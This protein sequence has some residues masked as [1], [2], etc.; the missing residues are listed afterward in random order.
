M[1]NFTF[2]LILLFSVTLMAQEEQDTVIVQKQILS[3]DFG[4]GGDFNFGK[5]SVNFIKVTTDSRC[6]R[7][8]NCIWAGEAK[9]LLGFN[10]NGNYFEK[11]V[12]VSGGGADIPL[13][14]DLLMQVSQLRPYPET[15]AGIAPE[16]YSL[17]ISAVFP[18]ED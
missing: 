4:V 2:L 6:P 18:A 9:V 14:N 7:Q 15:G 13:A 11:E 1:K 16:E 8:V 3:A 5:T 10:V 17:R 12:V